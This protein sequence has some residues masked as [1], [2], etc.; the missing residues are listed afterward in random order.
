[1]EYCFVKSNFCAY[2]WIFK[3]Y[4]MFNIFY[5]KIYII[6]FL[7]YAL[8]LQKKIECVRIDFLILIYV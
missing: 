5:R 6:H 8:I 7:F 1:M 2:K 4:G 3:G